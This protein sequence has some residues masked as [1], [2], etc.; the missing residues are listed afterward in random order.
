MAIK[1]IEYEVNIA[2]I[3]PATEQYGGT[4]GDHRV[5]QLKFA[6][7]EELYGGITDVSADGK[8]MY[9]FDV[10]D[11]EGGVWSSD[12][13]ELTDDTVSL[14]LEERH[15]R[16][17]GKIT[18]YLVITSLS[19]DN[20]TEVELYSF[21]AVLRLKNRPEGTHQDGE[22]YESVTALA[23]V[24][25]NKAL[26]AA[27]SAEAAVTALEDIDSAIA[28]SIDQTYDATSK[29][30]QSGIA[31]AGA[32]NGYVQK[33]SDPAD[34]LKV[35][36]SGIGGEA[37]MRSIEDVDAKE[38][39]VGDIVVR[40]VWGNLGTG[41][42]I[43][44]TDCVN[45]A[46]VNAA[47]I[48]RTD[49]TYDATS[50]NAQSGIAMAGALNGYVQK[51]KG[52]GHTKQVYAVDANDDT[53]GDTTMIVEDNAFFETGFDYGQIPTRQGNGNL[54]T[55]TPVKDLDCVNL[56]YVN[57]AISNLS[58]LK[59][60]IVAELP[61]SGEA[62]TLY[63]LPTSDTQDQN[64]YDEY[65]YTNGAWEK[66]G[67]AA[68]EVD[69]SDYLK[70]PATEMW[71]DCFLGQHAGTE[72]NVWITVDASNGLAIGANGT[73]FV[74]PA[75]KAMIAEKKVGRKPIPPELLD[76][77]VKVGLT[78]NT[79]TLTDE[80]KTAAQSWL[81]INSYELVEEITVESEGS[82]DK[83]TTPDGQLYSSLY[84]N[85]LVSIYNATDKA[86]TF[87]YMYR[88]DDC[89][90]M[91]T[92]SLNAG[93]FGTLKSEIITPDLAE[94]EFTKRAT[95]GYGTAVNKGCI[96]TSNNVSRILIGGCTAG[97]VIKIYGMKA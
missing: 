74:S 3:T 72:E 36:T 29:N 69:L 5:I 82:V 25:K 19:E 30:A 95:S 75:T 22:N 13:V 27:Q 85:M 18:V 24:A 54:M 70:T 73:L 21:P 97:T 47:I 6:L 86:S 78:T 46:Y 77:A 33:V 20:E 15:T 57:A 2:G 42:P 43:D 88:G 16:F 41:E 1:T 60:V 81:G 11:G 23:E 68:V 90:C 9:R 80:E 32:L 83:N 76:Y 35:Y 28:D 66:I 12:A 84:Q 64:L 10:Y 65:I 63:F 38:F 52:N 48:D 91:L 79:E 17:G 26:E 62:D 89:L 7:S 61:E 14:E 31:M 96:E 53:Y 44:A 59:V 71:G 93:E 87:A 45:L 56:A 58:G 49:Q 37:V 34:Y 40:N 67:S 8:A 51:V 4:Q 92:S 50:K 94:W 55:N 39:V